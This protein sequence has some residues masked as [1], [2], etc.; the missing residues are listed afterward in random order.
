LRTRHLRKRAA[1]RSPGSRGAARRRR[2][3]PPRCG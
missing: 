3:S 1:S 2:S